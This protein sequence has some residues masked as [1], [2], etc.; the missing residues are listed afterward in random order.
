MKEIEG[1]AKKWKDRPCSWHG[2][3]HIVKMSILPRAIYRFIVIPMKIPTVFFHRIGTN[4]TKICMEPQRSHE[5]C[6]SNLEK[7]QS[8]SMTIP[9]Y[10][11]SY[12]AVLIKTV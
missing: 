10:K 9:G 4:N 8:W 11:L 3:T 2:R 1:K 7:E 12:K 6:Q 5:D